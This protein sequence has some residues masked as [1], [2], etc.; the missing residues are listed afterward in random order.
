[1]KRSLQ[2]LLL[3]TLILSA[4][5]PVTA[6]VAPTAAPTKVSPP[7]PTRPPSGSPLQALEPALDGL[8]I[9]V[10]HPWF[11]TDA[12]LFEMMAEE[13]NSKNPWG[14]R[15]E[16]EGQTSYSVL[17]TNVT[18]S[19]ATEDRP[20]MVIAL[21]EQARAWD[22][23]GFVVDLAPYVDDPVYG[24]SR[25]EVRDVPQVFWLQDAAGV[26]RLAMPFQRT[27]HFLL[28]NKTWAAELGYD[29]P[30]ADPEEF[31]LQACAATRALTSDAEGEND[32]LGGWVVDTDPMTALS[33]M[34]AFEGGVMEGDGYRFLTPN[35]IEAFKFL[36]ALQEKGCA[37][38]P[39]AEVEPLGAFA[40]RH[41]LFVTADLGDF[42]QVTR[43]FAS[44]A[45]RD[46]WVPLAFPG[47]SHQ[48]VQVQGSS[49]VMLAA[50]EEARLAAWLFMDWL[51]SPE[52]D[53][54]SVKTT[55]LF[56]VRTASLDLLTDYASS[57]PRW[58][59]ALQWV[60][61]GDIQPQLGSWRTVRVMLGD[62]F[63]HI[64]RVSLPSG[65]VPAILAQ[66]ESTSHELSR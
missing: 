24:W 22:E 38:M 55:G 20:D 25:E 47:G 28:W 60:P 30:P 35:N 11:G 16:T 18:A 8:T 64:F 1:M 52:N 3:L 23:D 15:V 6:P 63:N 21:P 57:H 58:E 39:A 31:S 59:Q 5:A 51:L 56:P 54:R 9:R 34:R 65:Q 42:A 19:L 53:A 41:A 40:R 12:G 37:W 66:M 13:F 43:E 14:F 29:A 2:S 17:Y 36:R 62:G 49:L 26:R 45:N 48:P 10:W 32:G 44:A 4:C 46:D 50:G 61:Q 7:V 27:G 33:W